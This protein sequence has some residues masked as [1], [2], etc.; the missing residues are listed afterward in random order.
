M[1]MK[2][3]LAFAACCI[4]GA[5]SSS[6]MEIRWHL[7]DGSTEIEHREMEEHEA[8]GADVWRTT[9]SNG[10]KVYV[11]YSDKLQVVDGVTIPAQGWNIR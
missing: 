1:N 7:G 9:Y 4:A 11:N 10:V 6:D 5:A 8:V 2:N 3:V